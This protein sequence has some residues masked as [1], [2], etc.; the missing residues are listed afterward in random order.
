MQSTYNSMLQQQQ[1]IESALRAEISADQ[2]E[3]EQLKNGIRVRMSGALLYGEGVVELTR[4]GIA[5]LDKVAPQFSAETYEIDVVGNTDDLPIDRAYA[6]RFPTNWELAGER[7]GDRRP[8][9]AGARSRPDSDADSLG[10]AVPPRGAERFRRGPGAQPPYRDPLA[11]ALTVLAVPPNGARLT[12][13]TS[14]IVRRRRCATRRT[15]RSA[16]HGHASG[17][18]DGPFALRGLA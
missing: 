5:A 6:A 16:V 17:S 18:G 10:R 2:V 4:T 15:S 1:S 9:S 12:A 14:R 11:P 13:T 3:I 8:P 7:A